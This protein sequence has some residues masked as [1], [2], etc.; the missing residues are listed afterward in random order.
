MSWITVP[1]EGGPRRLSVAR[2]AQGVWV[3]W[4][5]GAMFVASE[6]RSASRSASADE[7]RAPMTG[8]VVSV[9][10]S[11]DEIVAKD[12]VLVVLEAMKM[13]YRIAAP[14]DG[15]VVGLHCRE[16]ELVE[17]GAPLVTLAPAT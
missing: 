6:Q 13:E 4:P 14:E 7:L 9:R 5:G 17:L 2:T 1:G 15:K 8:K 12:H 3:G 11:V 16:G 10:V